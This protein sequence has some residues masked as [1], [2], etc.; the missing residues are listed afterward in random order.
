M[1]RLLYRYA[2]GSDDYVYRYEQGEGIR[3]P[4]GVHIDHLGE[5]W[6]DTPFWALPLMLARRRFWRSVGWLSK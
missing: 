4:P 3:L 1:R 6:E 5:M 2:I